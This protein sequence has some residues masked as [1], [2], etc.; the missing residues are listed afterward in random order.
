MPELLVRLL[1][2]GPLAAVVVRLGHLRGALSRDGAIAAAV[3]GTTTV[4]GG[5]WWWGVLLLAFFVSS[6]ALSRLRPERAGRVQ[7]RGQQRDAVQVLANGGIATAIAATG[8]LAPGQHDAARVAL[9]CGAIAAVNAD[10]WATELGRLSQATPWLITT[11]RRVTPG[12]SGGITPLGT[13]ASALGALFIGGLAA[14]G[15]GLGAVPA[16][17]WT[18]LAGTAVA[19]LTGSLV[20]SLLGATLQAGY[21]DRMTGHTTER[22]TDAGGAP[23]DLIRGIAWITNDVVNGAASLAG[24]TIAAVVWRIST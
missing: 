14:L 23:N 10:T 7:A 19:G 24:A 5:G 21:R 15:A 6:S 4:A 9:F 3:V 17:P 22:R 18:L 12:T 13:A 16:S 20:D 1:L 11:G 2:A 8:L